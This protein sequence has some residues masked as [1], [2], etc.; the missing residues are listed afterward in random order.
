M[1]EFKS[2]LEF[3]AFLS[4]VIAK[5]NTHKIAILEA[6]AQYIEDE[7]KRKFG[8]YQ[9]EAGPYSKW[10]ELADSTKEDRARKGFSPDEPL[11]RTGELRDSIVH[12][13]VGSEAV[14]GSANDIM[15]YQEL[16]TA[17]I[18]PR[19]VLGPAAFQGKTK[20]AKIVAS[21]AKAWL[22]NQDT[23][24]KDFSY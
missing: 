23:I 21:G 15:V 1:N 9:E 3:D 18:P 10:P 22:T 6:S 17:T 16:G 12:S 5:E 24:K 20:I 11:Y 4:T 19:P 13:V 2:L 14:I 7:A 8:V